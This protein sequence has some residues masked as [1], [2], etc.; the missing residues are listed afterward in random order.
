MQTR[1]QQWGNSLAVRIPKAFAR[2]AQIAAGSAV[3]ISVV[4]GKL[5]V[6]RAAA[7]HYSL[8]ELLAGITDDNLHG[9]WH[10]GPAVGA[11]EW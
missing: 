4:D 5:V 1:V 10:T 8:D 9:E 11:E 6:E 3:D 7:P 2:E